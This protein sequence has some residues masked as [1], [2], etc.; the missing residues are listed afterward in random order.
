MYGLVWLA[1]AAFLSEAPVFLIPEKSNTFKIWLCSMFMYGSM[2]LAANAFL[3]DPS[4]FPHSRK[5][6]HF[7]NLAVLR[8]IHVYGLMWLAAK[9]ALAC[10]Q[11]KR[12]IA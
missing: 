11:L 3:S 2:W 12:I 8:V 9:D 5:I 4:C 1:A 10:L 7:Q 6:K